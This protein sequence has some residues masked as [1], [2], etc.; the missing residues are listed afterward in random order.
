[1]C[2]ILGFSRK[3]TNINNDFIETGIRLLK[4]RG[5]DDNGSFFT[6]DSLIALAH[7]RLS[8][9]DLSNYGHQPMFDITERYILVFNGEIYNFKE[10]KKELEK[11]YT[12]SSN[13]DTEV[14]LYSYIHY[15]LDFLKILNGI[16]S[17]AIYD[18]NTK[19]VIIARDRFG[20][21]P[22]YYTITKSGFYF[23]SE[24]KALMTLDDI[25]LE[26]DYSGIESY[27]TYL[28]SP[29]PNT[30][31]KDI[32][33]LEQASYL[34]IQEGN[35]TE[36]DFFYA[37]SY[38][39]NFNLEFDEIL[40]E[41]DLKLEKAVER[42]MISDVPI[43]AF[44]SGGLDSSSIVAFAKKFAGNNFPT[45]TIKTK[46]DLGMADDYYYAQ[47]VSR[48]LN[49]KLHNINIT[50]E[51]F[52][53]LE[54]MIYFLDEPQADLA[55]ILVSYIS[56]IAREEYN[57]KVLL[58]GAGGD[59]IFS[60]Y[61]RHYAL[62]ID[63]KLSK[64]SKSFRKYSK[65]L[66]QN[67]PS[68]NSFLRR[69]KKYTKYFDYD[70]DEKIISYFQWIDKENRRKLYSDDFLTKLYEVDSNTELLLEEQLKSLDKN[71]TP[72]NKMLHLDKKFFL[73]DHNLNYTDKMGMK[74]GVEIRV[75][76][77]DNDLV[78]FTSTIPSQYKQ[79]GKEGK[80]IF[81]KVMEKY[82]PNEVIYRPKTGFGTPLKNWLHYELKDYINSILSKENIQKRGIF[83]YENLQKMIFED[84]L[85]KEDYSYIILSILSIELWCKIFIDNRNELKKGR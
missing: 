6:N 81:K 44:L 47:K 38:N 77:L 11:T 37:D 46:N 64:I 42:Q 52:F 51:L 17:I 53:D 68:N 66:I 4:H 20:V 63:E 69:L 55:P 28:W 36:K 49:V 65:N 35:I 60:G 76:L 41:L 85:G 33:K 10:I 3:Q 16:F 7:T 9:L 22:L 23:A 21:K 71:T 2:G 18:K 29:T 67:L 48:H 39:E 72:L 8:I 59:D 14:V 74:E 79:N 31:L 50:H 83:N 43:G 54:N 32:K 30:P 70:G 19:K 5:P 40:N 25:N 24:L 75:P 45:F 84:K 13:S 27:M 62:K 78:E 56:K 15:G 61:R 26:F 58:S 34:I 80:Y 1:M 82:L 57:I 12:F 73:T